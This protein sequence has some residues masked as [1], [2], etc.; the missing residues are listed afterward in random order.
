[1]KFHERTFANE[2]VRV[3]GSH[4]T[5]CRFENCTLI[6]GGGPL[7]SLEHCGFYD[8]QWSF[9]DAAMNTLHFLSA[10]YH[11]F[12][13]GG[14]QLIEHTFENIRRGQL[15]HFGSQGGEEAA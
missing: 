11:G 7:P 9:A 10:M 12:G 5:N 4:F 2:E 8:S 14:Q 6:Y 13:E 1:M 15:P 3:D